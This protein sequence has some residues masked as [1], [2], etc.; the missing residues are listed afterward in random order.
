MNSVTLVFG[1]M[2]IGAGFVM[3]IRRLHDRSV[4]ESLAVLRNARRDPAPAIAA[5]VGLVVPIVT[6]IASGIAFV[7]VGLMGGSLAPGSWF[8]G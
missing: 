4:H 6:S 7:A 5:F 3:L 2:L 1:V 8:G